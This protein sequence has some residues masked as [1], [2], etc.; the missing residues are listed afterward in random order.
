M[1][2]N[3]NLNEKPGTSTP[4]SA[5]ICSAPAPLRPPHASPDHPLHAHYH[6][7]TDD[8]P[9]EEA[10]LEAKWRATKGVDAEGKAWLTPRMER[11][12]IKLAKLMASWPNVEGRDGDR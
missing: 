4:L 12:A 5:T 8:Y 7:E 11:N 10:E 2:N 9:P 3:P 1:K 6:P